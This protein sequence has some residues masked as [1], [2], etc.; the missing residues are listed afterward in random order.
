MI[1]NKYYGRKSAGE[2]AS[3]KVYAPS[4]R[5][6]SATK[7]EKVREGVYDTDHFL[8]SNIDE[9]GDWDVSIDSTIKT[10][11]IEEAK[12]YEVRE[13]ISIDTTFAEKDP[14]WSIIGLTK[15]GTFGSGFSIPVA[16]SSIGTLVPPHP[17]GSAK[18]GYLSIPFNATEWSIEWSVTIGSSATSQVGGAIL[19]LQDANANEML[20]AYLQDFNG[21]QYS[22]YTA[23]RNADMSVY[24]APQD[25]N[26]GSSYKTRTVTFKLVYQNG[27]LT[28]YRNGTQTYSGAYTFNELAEI[29]LWFA[30]SAGIP[31]TT[32]HYLKAEEL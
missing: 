7:G 19:E 22:A 10:V 21:S 24:F 5:L 28:A 23:I 9:Y 2:T 32:Y 27:I 1:L 17:S 16:Q 20:E 8:I 29:R 12:V 31:A 11:D 14:D 4:N 15:G 6:V 3:I 25:G 13:K 18:G 30:T 26:T